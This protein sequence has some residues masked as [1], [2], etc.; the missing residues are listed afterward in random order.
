MNDSI[1]FKKKDILNTFLLV[2]VYACAFYCIQFFL[3]KAA[4]VANFPTSEN[5]VHWDAGWYKTIAD[6]GY[7][8]SNSGQSNSGFFMLFPI[9]WKITHLGVWGISFLNIIF[10]AIGFSLITNLFELSIADKL[11]WLSIPTVI[12]VFIPYSEALFFFLSA[13]SVAAIVNRIKWL[14][15]LSLFFLA[16][17]RATT[18]FLIPAFLFMELLSNDRNN[19]RKSLISYF[20]NYTV[21]LLA[22]LGCFILYQYCKTGIWFAY[23]IQQSK[24]WNR[25]YTLPEFPLRNPIGYNLV[26][27]SALAMFVCFIAF[28]FLVRTIKQW[29][30]AN[31]QQ[32]KLLVLSIGYL[33]MTLYIILSYN[34]PTTVLG[35]FRY[36]MMNPF[37][38]IFLHHFTKNVEYK[39]KDYLLAFFIANV[40]WFFFGSF[41]HIQLIL[42]YSFDTALLFIYMAHSN[43]KNDWPVI[44][45]FGI[46]VFFQIMFFQQFITHTLID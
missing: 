23:F 21:P 11:L 27:L 29:I 25:Q 31:T 26:W 24:Q 34:V 22:G 39:R 35:A 42:F 18:V 17:T 37:F 19:W 9:V 6:D 14:I 7:V 4:L 16:L 32:D 45:L 3:F 38:Y 33:T 36:A 12:F 2:I 5:L 44:V 28:L 43:K 41:M 15:W 20:I 30:Y 46:N 13:V 1:L 40:V 8:F 10:F